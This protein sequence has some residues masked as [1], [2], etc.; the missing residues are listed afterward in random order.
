MITL[1]TIYWCPHGDSISKAS[2]ASYVLMLLS[3]K[4]IVRAGEISVAIG[5]A[6]AM[7]A[8]HVI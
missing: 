7:Q 5:Y 8:M 1:E 3:C 2:M 6:P 4:L